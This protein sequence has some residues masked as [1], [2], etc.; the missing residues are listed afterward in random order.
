MYVFS[1]LKNLSVPFEKA[2]LTLRTLGLGLSSGLQ[3]QFNTSSD[4]IVQNETLGAPGLVT[5]ELQGGNFN[6][7]EP[8]GLSY[9]QASNVALPLFGLSAE[10][11]VYMSFDIDD[12]LNIQ[13]YIDDRVPPP[14]DGST[15]AYYRWYICETYFS[16]YTYTTLAWVMGQY[17]PQNP[18]CSPVG[19]KRV[20]V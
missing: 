12:C 9:N 1:H 16:S 17:P 6:V 11:V 4:S 15:T 7:S 18:T 10:S 5:Y 3:F 2:V 8:L 13:S 14:Y 20:F 19:V